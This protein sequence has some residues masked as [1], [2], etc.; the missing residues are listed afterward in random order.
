MERFPQAMH[1]VLARHDAILQTAITQHRGK[2]VVTTGDGVLASLC[3]GQ[4]C[5]AGS[6]GRA[7]C[8]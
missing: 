1:G 2:I 6:P 8:A 3:R 4:R 5:H 7:A